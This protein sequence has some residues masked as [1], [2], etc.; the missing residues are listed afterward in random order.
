M[1]TA[2]N[3][4]NTIDELQKKID[5]YEQ[6]LFRV[7]NSEKGLEGQDTFIKYLTDSVEFYRTRQ[8]RQTGLMDNMVAQDLLAELPHLGTL[9]PETIKRA[10]CEV[11]SKDAVRPPDE[12]VETEEYEETEEPEP[13]PEPD[14]TTERDL[15]E[16]L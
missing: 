10:C 13:E 14:A 15:L 1:Y 9:A 6:A 5:K 4:Q 7:F 16:D 11:Q 8:V 12:F 2:E 3:L